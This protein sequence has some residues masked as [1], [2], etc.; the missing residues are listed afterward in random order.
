MIV[1]ELDHEANVGPWLRLERDG[2]VPLVWKIRGR[3]ARLEPD[4]PWALLAGAK[5][6]VRLVAM[7]LASNAIG[8][9]VDVRAAARAAREAG[10][11]VFVDAVHFAPHGPI[12]V[13]ALGAD[14]LAFSGYKIFGPHIGFLW[15]A[16]NRSGGSFP[17]ASSSSPRSLRELSR[18]EPRASR[19]WRMAAAL[20]YVLE[21]SGSHPRPRDGAG[22]GAPRGARQVPGLTI[23]GDADP[24]R[25]EGRV[26][27]VAFTIPGR[28]PRSVVEGLAERGIHAR[29]G[30]LYAPRLIEAAGIDPAIGVRVSLCHTSTREE[31]ARLGQALRQMHGESTFL[32]DLVIALAAASSSSSPAAASASPPL[33]ASCSPGSSS[34]PA[35]SA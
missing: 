9:I 35:R 7:P 1:T 3:E 10:A 19:R 4:D 31:I 13:R 28:P 15:G 12:D 18:A 33:S 14:F 26:P 17:R 8:R 24:E 25:V 11:L 5:G 29:D 32:R 6:R 22:L 30:H 2:V 23:L 27:N 16:A 21:V 20:R 34:G